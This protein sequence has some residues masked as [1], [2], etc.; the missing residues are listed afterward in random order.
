M[1][2][3]NTVFSYVDASCRIGLHSL[4]EHMYQVELSANGMAV[5]NVG[6]AHR[7]C[8]C[9]KTASNAGLSG[10]G[11]YFNATRKQGTPKVLM[12]VDCTLRNNVAV[13][14]GGGIYAGA[15]LTS[16]T[17]NKLSVVNNSAGTSGGA[18]YLG[19]NP[20]VNITSCDFQFNSGTDTDDTIN[21]MFSSE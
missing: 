3:T 18:I 4:A 6:H 10:S 11:V 2:S 12:I 8:S 19:G 16:V 9:S 15:G 17:F 7:D 13:E 14:W 5:H 20:N 21:N 1:I